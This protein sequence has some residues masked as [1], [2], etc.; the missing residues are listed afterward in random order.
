[1]RFLSRT[2][3]AILLALVVLVALPYSAAALQDTWVVAV[4]SLLLFISMFVGKRHTLE[5]WQ[6]GLFVACYVGYVAFLISR[7]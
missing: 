2:R 4:D 3:V 5:R 1:M 6:G 7:G